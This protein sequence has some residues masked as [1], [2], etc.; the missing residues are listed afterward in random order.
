MKI[1]TALVLPD[2]KPL[3]LEFG[4]MTTVEDNILFPNSSILNY[5]NKFEGQSMVYWD[6]Y[7]CVTHSN[8]KCIQVL[9]KRLLD[10]FTNDNQ[11]WLKD[12]I[13]KDNEPN[14]SD[15]DI[16]VL[17]GTK[18]GVGN[19]GEKVLTTI[20]EKGLIS[21]LL[22][23]WDMFSRDPEM[24]V[25]K[26]YAYARTKEAEQL[27]KEWN[28][29][30][31]VTGEWV[32]RWN[33]QEASKKGCLQVYVN[34]WYE[35][36]GKYYNPSDK[37]NHAVQLVDYSLIE[38][39]DTYEPQIKKLSSWQ[40]AYYWALKINIKEK[41]MAKPNIV[42]N[43]LVILVQ[44]SGAIGLYLD[45]KIIID[46]V[47]KVLSVFMARNAKNGNFSGGP[48][49]SLTQEQWDMFEKRTL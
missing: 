22:G 6:D 24:T 9:I 21:Q 42:N 5:I 17:S 39:N 38:I 44:G 30:F 23:D 49:K 1:N 26:Y 2:I 18:P 43:S 32:Q 3:S 31:E 47:G 12:N 40:D 36:D 41:S 46:D 29:R 15:R 4:G 19:S 48:V 8:Q 27:A 7:G 35:K 11:K 33:W 34:A 20:Q 10:T 14:F 37:Y 28:E 16:V 25:E 45:G 13:Y